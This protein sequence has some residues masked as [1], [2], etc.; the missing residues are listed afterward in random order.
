MESKEEK[1]TRPAG[2]EGKKQ[3]GKPP[4]KTG[5]TSSKK[6]TNSQN[7]AVVAGVSHASG[8]KNKTG[9]DGHQ[10]KE[11]DLVLKAIAKIDRKVDD[12]AKLIQ[13]QGVQMDY[14]ANPGD[15]DGNV[16]DE[17]YHDYH[18]GQ[19][20]LD[21]EQDVEN[22]G[23]ENEEPP[24]KKRKA[25]DSVSDMP[26][27]AGGSRF[28][29]ALSK[30]K[31]SKETVE[32]SIKEDIAKLANESFSQSIDKDQLKALIDS[33]HRPENC[34][35]LTEVRVNELIWNLLSAQTR[36]FD[37]KLQIVQSCM[38]KTGVIMARML[39]MI[40]SDERLSFIDKTLDAGAEGLTLLG[41][42]YHLLCIRRREMMKPDV[43]WRYTHLCSANVAHTS[44]LFGDD[45]QEEIKKIGDTNK[46]ANTV[47][48]NRQ[49]NTRGRARGRP[50]H[51]G[52]G[53]N[54]YTGCPRKK[55]TDF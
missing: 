15:G 37:E 23:Y 45:V 46:V 18:D 39:H 43:D 19:E 21:Y 40:D 12:N 4:V 11:L 38:A 34:T 48:G 29:V 10:N 13:K 9:A 16:N 44:F 24:Q 28:T 3:T 36:A 35:A 14:L 8:S 49:Y 17:Y 30:Y 31:K 6:S 50:L 27:S 20:E 51:R 26:P 47:R 22:E 25:D 55:G 1:E 7:S 5:K 42:A 41:Q 53:Y 52:M 33:V 54:P 32:D 2:D